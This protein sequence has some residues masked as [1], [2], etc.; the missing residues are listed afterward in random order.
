MTDSTHDDSASTVT[1]SPYA[2]IYDAYPNVRFLICGPRHPKALVYDTPQRDVAKVPLGGIGIDT[3]K[4]KPVP[5]DRIEQFA[6]TNFIGI[7]PG[8]VDVCAVDLD[9]SSHFDFLA[10]TFPGAPFIPTGTDPR[11]GHFF[12]RVDP[13]SSKVIGNGKIYHRRES[14]G[15]VR[16][17]SGYI[18]L[19]NP[20]AFA[21][22]VLDDKLPRVPSAKGL[23]LTQQYSTSNRRDKALDKYVEQ[24]QNAPSGERHDTMMQNQLPLIRHQFTRAELQPAIDAFC[25]FPGHDE[26]EFMTAWEGAKEKYI[27]NRGTGETLATTAD[28]LARGLAEQGIRLRFNTRAQQVEVLYPDQTQW[29]KFDDYTYAKLVVLFQRNYL[30]AT[31]DNVTH[32]SIAKDSWFTFITAL[33]QERSID[34]FA[35]YLS[36]LEWDETPRLS[37]WIE[38]LFKLSAHTPPDLARWASRSILMSAVERAIKPGCKVD[39]TIVLRGPIGIGKSSCLY[40]F[41]PPHYQD[42][43]LS[44]SF[45][46]RADDKTVA[47]MC[48]GPVFIEFAELG[49][50]RKAEVER[51]KAIASRQVD[52]ARMAYGRVVLD[53]PR[54]SVMI[55]TA[56][57]GQYLVDSS[58]NRRFIP[59][60][61]EGREQ[62]PTRLVKGVI[63]ANA[64]QLWA[65]AYHRVVNLNE[66]HIIPT[67]IHDI[68]MRAGEDLLVRTMDEDLIDQH[69]WGNR[70]WLL[71]EIATKIGKLD[72]AVIVDG[73][74]TFVTDPAAKLGQQQVMLI[75]NSLR[76]LGWQR[77][78]RKRLCGMNTTWWI[79]PGVDMK[80]AFE[81]TPRLRMRDEQLEEDERV[82][83][84][85]E[86]ARKRHE[87]AQRDEAAQAARDPDVPY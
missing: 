74:E 77:T 80:T 56:N 19:W 30:R 83:R 66:S 10:E 6:E 47:E 68:A 44:E 24:I 79:A 53:F 38:D 21:D 1:R 29:T 23:G 64:D 11:R 32:W 58:G 4:R 5:L 16:C 76:A 14:I 85:E 46:F 7:I 52:K 50:L 27:A 40:G 35:L 86:Q 75:S 12:V 28:G 73:V 45:D 3:V 78:P 33:S 15:E 36:R 59:I 37:T 71:H 65:E 63:S 69:D 13:A 55:G 41:F 57:P 70:A 54:R 39:T 61:V 49:G 9:K 20:E 82:Q 87:R 51:V 8:T 81:E 2:R 60:D 18:V 42:K 31:R 26:Q 84:E 17:I 72:R 34:P 43:W 25:A 48:V 22:V 67:E 62:N